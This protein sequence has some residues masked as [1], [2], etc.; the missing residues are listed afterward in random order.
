[1]NGGRWTV[2]GG[3]LVA[4]AIV[5]TGWMFRSRS[6]SSSAEVPNSRPTVVRASPPNFKFVRVPPGTFEMGDPHTEPDPREAL[7]P[8]NE[9]AH[10]HTVTLTRP[11]ELAT[12][13]VTVGEFSRFVRETGY[14]T[15]AEKIGRAVGYSRKVNVSGFAWFSGLTWRTAAV[16]HRDDVPVTVISWNDAE[17]FCRWAC[18]L[19][20]RSVRLPT[21]A[22][23]EYACRAGT[24]GPYYDTGDP[25]ELGWFADNAGLVAF[26][27]EALY[28]Q[29]GLQALKDKLI[30][31]R[32]QIHCV[33]L[34][35][36]NALGLYDM[37]GSVWQWCSDR[38]D[39]YPNGPVADPAGPIDPALKNRCA[40]GCSWENTAGVGTAFNRGT[41]APDFGYRHIGF[42]VAA[43]VP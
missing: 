36:P 14:K 23:W 7:S 39:I 5:G 24:T 35:K 1:M 18:R 3:C 22:E 42:R 13:P 4:I 40:R 19:T 27:A 32:C 6:A 41:W 31:A 21:E 20:G 11:F 17:A 12:Y 30:S 25:A 43:D 9:N 34:K 33:G 28:R 38:F 15:D 16:G 29:K 37:L 26:D 8:R 2:I 10:H